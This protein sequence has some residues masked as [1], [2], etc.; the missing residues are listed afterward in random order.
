MKI[1]KPGRNFP[2]AWQMTCSHCGCEFAFVDADAQADRDGLYI[3]CPNLACKN[4]MS[5]D[6][7]TPYAGNATSYTG[8]GPGGRD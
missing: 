6:K 2:T 8:T 1:L 4:V 5:V 7:S 3:C